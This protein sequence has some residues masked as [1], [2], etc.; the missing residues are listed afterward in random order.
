M[1]AMPIRIVT[2]SSGWLQL[3]ASFNKNWV[4]YFREALGLGLFMASAC[5]FSAML[6]SPK[7]AWYAAIPNLA[8][9]NILMGIAMGST[10]LLIFYSPL[11]APSG[12]QIN[13]AVSLSFL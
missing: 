10:A 2:G 1:R 8:I 12:S 9:K 5:F 13:P 6:F 11:T 3:K 7:S 4:H